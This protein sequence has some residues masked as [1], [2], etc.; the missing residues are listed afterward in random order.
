MFGRKEHQGDEDEEVAVDA[1]LASNLA[2]VEQSIDVYLKDPSV[3]LRTKLLDVLERLDAQIDRSDAYENSVI[4]SAA[5][6]YS[7]KGSVIGETSSV[8]AA[9]NISESVLLAQTILIKAAKREVTTPTPETLADLRAASQ[10]LAAERSK[11]V[12]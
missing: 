6:G 3:D 7:S 9:E 12:D 2:S 10:A 8:S 4:G 11:Q 1:T 5:L